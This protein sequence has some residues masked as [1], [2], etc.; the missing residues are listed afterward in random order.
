MCL[1]KKK[2]LLDQTDQAHSEHSL[3]KQ[4]VYRD[5]SCLDRLDHS[6]FFCFVFH[7]QGF[8]HVT[9]DSP[10]LYKSCVFFYV[11]CLFCTVSDLHM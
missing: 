11:F 3:A 9:E 8:A 10:I 5:S 6:H 7:C 4:P 2:G 1:K